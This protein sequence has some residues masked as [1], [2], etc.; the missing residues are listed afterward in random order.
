MSDV[1]TDPSTSGIEHRGRAPYQPPR[2][3]KVQLAADE[4]LTAGCKTS[5][6]G[7]NSGSAVACNYPGGPC[8]ITLGS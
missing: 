2:L 8:N 4:V 5:I 3:A 1:S 7:P 6:D